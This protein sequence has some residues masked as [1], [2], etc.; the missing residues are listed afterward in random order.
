MSGPDNGQNGVETK[1]P[2]PFE[3][4]LEGA[5]L[6]LMLDAKGF[7]RL[8]ITVEGFYRSFAAALYV[9]P[10][11]VFV[12]VA[13]RSFTATLTGEAPLP[14]GAALIAA[15]TLYYLCQWLAFPL[16]LLGIAR[17]FQLE[18]HY[19]AYVIAAN[20]SAVVTFAVQTL[21]L[22]SWGLGLADPGST[23]FLGFGAFLFSLY[24]RWAIATMVFEDRP[25]TAGAIALAD[26]MVGLSLFTLFTALFGDSA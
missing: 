1:R 25:L 23:S 9:L 16:M 22:L 7:A 8:D 11:Y 6:L 3:R 18:G 26:L 4:N 5:I 13:D 15:E 17:L 20:W 12:W 21:P 2:P 14:P 24:A 10:L 19:V